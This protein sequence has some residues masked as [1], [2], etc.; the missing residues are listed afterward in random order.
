MA[1]RRDRDPDA[2][3]ARAAAHA[4]AI[5]S[6]Y[7][8]SVKLLRKILNLQNELFQLQQTNQ[9]P[10]GAQRMEMKIL[11]IYLEK[12]FLE[13]HFLRI[14]ILKLRTKGFEHPRTPH[15]FFGTNNLI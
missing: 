14:N 13:D 2:R 5:Q 3:A 1:E 7:V 12:E 6:C 10:N 4:A 11:I 9:N 15:I 8:E